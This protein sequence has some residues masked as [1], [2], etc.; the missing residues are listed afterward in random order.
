MYDIMRKLAALCHLSREYD[1]RI[2]AYIG[3]SPAKCQG[4]SSLQAAK[5][6][7]ETLQLFTPARMSQLS[8]SLGLYLPD[9]LT[10]YFKLLPHFL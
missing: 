6:F 7:H 4:N 5:L 9:T 3:T 10:R 2:V 1:E 8:K